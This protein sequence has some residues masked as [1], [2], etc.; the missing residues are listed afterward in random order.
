VAATPAGVPPIP[1]SV[2]VGLQQAGLA[3]A[4]DEWAR[5]ADWSPRKLVVLRQTSRT[6]DEIEHYQ[7][8]IATDGGPLLAT[9]HGAA[10]HPLLRP[11]RAAQTLLVT[12]LRA[13]DAK[14][15]D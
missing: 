2:I 3:Y 5:Y 12:L 15:E 7:A 8:R 14:E 13:L 6:I 10:P 4:L 1:E 9:G 11:L